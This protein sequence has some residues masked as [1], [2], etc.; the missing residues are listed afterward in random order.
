VFFGYPLL[1]W[2]IYRY[3]L[4]RG[5]SAADARSYAGFCV[6]GKVPE[7]IGRLNYWLTK[8]RGQQATLIEYKQSVT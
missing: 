8:L 6:L 4:S 5:D 7:S 2:K 3:R 1:A